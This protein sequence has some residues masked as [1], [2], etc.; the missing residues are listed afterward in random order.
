MK[1][2]LAIFRAS[3]KKSESITLF[4]KQLEQQAV[5]NSYSLSDMINMV[6][7]ISLKALNKSK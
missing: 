7:N 3:Q 2:P 6:F 4:E 5:V 1:A